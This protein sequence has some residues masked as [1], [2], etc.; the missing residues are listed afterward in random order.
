MRGKNDEPPGKP[1]P[2]QPLRQDLQRRRARRRGAEAADAAAP[3]L[4]LLPPE[5][6]TSRF[7]CRQQRWFFPADS[8]E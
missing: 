6:L 2:L 8:A 4:P 1:E 3:D 7:R 5:V